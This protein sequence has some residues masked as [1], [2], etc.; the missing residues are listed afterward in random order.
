M[1]FCWTVQGA[2]YGPP[3]GTAQPGRSEKFRSGPIPSPE[4]GS[5]TALFRARLVPEAVVGL[6]HMSQCARGV[7]DM[8]LKD[9]I[10]RELWDLG[11]NDHEVS[12]FCSR[13]KRRHLTI[14][15]RKEKNAAARL[16]YER[17]SHD[18]RCRQG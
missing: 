2:R 16:M 1:D 10:T 4:F 7:A 18:T 3:P 5:L 8:T 11:R 15:T 6:V 17:G 12:Y 14:A 9:T 13:C